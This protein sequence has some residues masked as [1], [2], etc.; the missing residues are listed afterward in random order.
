MRPIARSFAYDA[1]IVCVRCPDRFHTMPRSYAYDG[2]I[3]SIRC[4]DRMRSM[5]RSFPHDTPIICV[6]SPDRV[7]P[8]ADHLR[9]MPRSYSH[10]RLT[11]S[12]AAVILS[13]EDGEG[14][15]RVPRE[16][17]LRFAQDD[18]RRTCRSAVAT[19][20]L[21][22][23]IANSGGFATALLHRWKILRFIQGDSMARAFL[24]PLGS[25]TARALLPAGSGEKVP[26]G[27]MRGVGESMARAH[28]THAR[29]ESQ[30]PG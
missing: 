17:I 23:A 2:P 19:E 24:P 20:P 3:I 27:R 22:L 29:R 21:L 26:G 13:R 15:S 8:S 9:T 1:P 4:P 12:T 7:R 10:R 6:P 18:S 16:K 5:A 30:Q 11:K 28:S 25:P 14:S